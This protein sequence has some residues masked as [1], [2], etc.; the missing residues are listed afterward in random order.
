MVAGISR[1]ARRPEVAVERL[2]HTVGMADS[3]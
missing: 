2:R 3:D 1:P